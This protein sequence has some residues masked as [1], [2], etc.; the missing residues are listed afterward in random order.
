[1]V[2]QRREHTAPVGAERTDQSRGRPY[3]RIKQADGSWKWKHRLVA[4]KMLGRELEPGERVKFRNGDST[5]CRE[6]NLYVSN[7]TFQKVYVYKRKKRIEAAIRMMEFK[8]K[9]MNIELAGLKE[10]LKEFD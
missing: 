2:Y 7:P 8:I 5:D 10:Q 9:E 6:S 4:E 3:I 1:M